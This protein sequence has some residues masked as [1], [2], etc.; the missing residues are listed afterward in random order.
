L[1]LDTQK[2]KSVQILVGKDLYVHPSEML[3][4]DIKEM[5]GEDNF[6]LTVS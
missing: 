1:Q 5:V 4:N 3:L 2:Y 6:A